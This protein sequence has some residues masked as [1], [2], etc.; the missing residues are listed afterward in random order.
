MFQTVSCSPYSQAA[1][2][3]ATI[4]LHRCAVHLTS[5]RLFR[6]WDVAKVNHLGCR[7][8]W[9]SHA[10]INI[11]KAS[12]NSIH[13]FQIKF[14]NS[15]FWRLSNEVHFSNFTTTFWISPPNTQQRAKRLMGCMPIGAIC[16]PIWPIGAIGRPIGAIGPILAWSWNVLNSKV[17]NP[18]QH[19]TY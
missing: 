19:S 8:I 10:D 15:N 4:D 11:L 5:P 9:L 16:P 6:L 17:C 18:F 2:F 12:K 1:V 7:V 13:G 3:P 14:K